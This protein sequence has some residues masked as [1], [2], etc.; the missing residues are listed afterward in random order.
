MIN[1]YEVHVKVGSLSGLPDN[2]QK[3]SDRPLFLTI[4]QNDEIRSI[5]PVMNI[6][7]YQRPDLYF[8][9]LP[10]PLISH[11]NLKILI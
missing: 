4:S 2:E 8:S 6:S 5:H 7:V 9:L 11:S 3:F 10:L 1:I